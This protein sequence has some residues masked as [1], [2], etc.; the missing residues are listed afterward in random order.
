MRHNI[1]LVIFG[2]QGDLAKRKLLP[3]LYRLDKADLLPD[4]ARIASV[5]RHQIS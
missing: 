2:S 4:N 5:A 1:D 3:A